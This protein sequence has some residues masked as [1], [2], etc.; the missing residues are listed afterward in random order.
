MSPID[1]PK[2][3]HDIVTHMTKEAH[4]IVTHMTK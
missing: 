4:D 1:A 3:A 2:E